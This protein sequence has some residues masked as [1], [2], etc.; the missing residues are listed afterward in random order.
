M[1]HCNDDFVQTCTHFSFHH[2]V[3]LFLLIC[4]EPVCVSL[5]EREAV[6]KMNYFNFCYHPQKQFRL[7]LKPSDTILKPCLQVKTLWMARKRVYLLNQASRCEILH[8]IVILHKSFLQSSIDVHVCTRLYGS[9]THSVCVPLECL[10]WKMRTAFQ[11]SR[12]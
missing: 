7:R 4:L 6:T 2:S 8:C 3:D 11:T 1:T 12:D 10:R 9:K 5:F